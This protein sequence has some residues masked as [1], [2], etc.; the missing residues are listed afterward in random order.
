MSIKRVALYTRTSTGD[1]RQYHENQLDKLREFAAG[2]SWTIA[3]EYTDSAS[4]AAKKRPELD[5]LMAAAARRA[6]DV[7]LVFDLSRLTRSG[8]M[9]A[10]ALIERLNS[11]NV[12]FWSATEEHFR[13]TGPAG[14]MFIALAAYLATAERDTIRNRIYAGIARARKAGKAIGRPAAVIDRARVAAMRESGDS[15][16]QIAKSLGVS[17]ATID[18]A[19]AAAKR[20]EAAAL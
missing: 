4:G 13:T 3:A 20:K 7:V 16:R 8:P 18:R 11:S 15:T 10:F 14:Q 6:F 1:G 9:E 12:E 2:M 5:K 17:K 19:L